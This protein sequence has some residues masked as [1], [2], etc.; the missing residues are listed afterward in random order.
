[1]SSRSTGSADKIRTP[2]PI[3]RSKLGPSAPAAP[4][5]VPPL[6]PGLA[7]GLD[8]RTLQRLKRGLIAPEGKLDLHNMTQDEAHRALNRFIHHGQASGRRCVLVITGKGRSSAGMIG[9]L[10]Q[11]V[12]LWLNE[13]ELR[14][15]VLAFTYA[16]PAHGGD[17]ALFV[18][19]KRLGKS[20]Q[21]DP[22]DD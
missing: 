7:A 15:R 4:P 11:Q 5:T 14:V 18:L 13:P 10:K 8:K 6:T 17:G 22:R 1:M 3:V 19:L 12:P 2:A 9:V 16:T 20:A 21:R